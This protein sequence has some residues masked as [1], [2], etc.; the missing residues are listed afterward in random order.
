VRL[1]SIL[2]AKK[3][4]TTVPTTRHMPS[5]STT[6]EIN[7]LPK[8]TSPEL[9]LPEESSLL[10][11]NEIPNNQIT[12]SMVD[13]DDDDMMPVVASVEEEQPIEDSTQSEIDPTFVIVQ[14]A[15]CNDER[16][17]LDDR[18]PSCSSGYESS[19]VLNPIHEGEDDEIHCSSSCPSIVSPNSPKL[20]TNNQKKITRKRQ[21]NGYGKSRSRAR[22][23]KSRTP[24]KQRL[25]DDNEDKED[26]S[27]VIIITSD[28]IEQHLRTLFMATNETR[29]TRTRPIKTPTRLVE[30]IH[31]NNNS[32]TMKTL[33]PDS[34]VFDILSS[35]TTTDTISLNELAENSQQPC[36]Y[37]VII[38]NKPN[39]L[40]LTIKKV[41]QP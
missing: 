22:S 23:L 7:S 18:I 30:E 38:S 15:D 32:T 9:P 8:S 17:Q 21:R 33:E 5:V 6:N 29:R 12:C 36:T 27:L 24:K 10:A 37:N 2:G 13:D 35:S 20:S 3:R 26:T 19:A 1:S 16:I 28:K 39:K 34:N 4:K 11:S 41:V 31:V 25:I 40:G 14:S